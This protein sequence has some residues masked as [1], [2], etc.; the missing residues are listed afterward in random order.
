MDLQRLRKQ[1]EEE[2]RQEVVYVY[3]ALRSN[4]GYAVD[5]RPKQVAVVERVGKLSANHLRRVERHVLQVVLIGDT[6]RSIFINV[7]DLTD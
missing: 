6:A 2:R 7:V 5:A 1:I 3:E 4:G